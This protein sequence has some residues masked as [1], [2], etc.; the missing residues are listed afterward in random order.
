MGFGFHDIQ[1]VGGDTAV[2][3]ATRYLMDGPGIEPG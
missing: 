3:I 1:S 2:G